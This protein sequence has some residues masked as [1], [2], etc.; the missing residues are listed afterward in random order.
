MNESEILLVDILDQQERVEAWSNMNQKQLSQIFNE[1]KNAIQKIKLEQ[2]RIE[3]QKRKELRAQK[4]IENQKE[5]GICHRKKFSND[6]CY[7]SSIDFYSCINDLKKC[8]S[9]WE[10]NNQKELN[11]IE[12]VKKE[13]DTLNE[14]DQLNYSNLDQEDQFEKKFDLDF[15]DLEES[16]DRFRDG[17]INYIHIPTGFVYVW[18][19]R[20]WTTKS[21]RVRVAINHLQSELKALRKKI[22]K[23]PN[24]GPYFSYNSRE[25]LRKSF[26][27]KFPDY[28][29]DDL[30]P[31]SYLPSMEN[32][33]YTMY[34]HISGKIFYLYQT[35]K[36]IWS[37]NPDENHGK[38]RDLSNIMIGPS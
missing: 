15:C 3:M 17:S 18:S 7:E 28:Q 27:Q 34:M 13:I 25:S 23:K 22:Q 29:Y 10:Q 36:P 31:N 32:K 35:Y 14:E 6:L 30:V 33:D 12:E 2:K 24:N 37:N 19:Q 9:I 1:V 16:P 26:E 11:R 38:K 21:M 20:R 5:C 8:S 4:L